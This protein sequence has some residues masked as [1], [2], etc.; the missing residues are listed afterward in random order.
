MFSA[1]H[2]VEQGTH[3]ELMAI[4]GGEYRSLWEVQASG[5]QASAEVRQS[6]ISRRR[7]WLTREAEHTEAGEWR[8]GGGLA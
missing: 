2:L 4:D 8:G 7:R 3:A 1:G 5:F 6:W